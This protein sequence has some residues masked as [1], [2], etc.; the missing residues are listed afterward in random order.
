MYRNKKAA[1]LILAV[2]LIFG[3]SFSSAA[4]ELIP[5]EDIRE[6]KANYKTAE[7]VYAEFTDEKEI[8]GIEVMSN[9]TEF[10]YTDDPVY[11]VAQLVKGGDIVK[12]GDPVF[13]IKTQIDPSSIYEKER[14]LQRMEEDFESGRKSREDAIA[15]ME[16]KISETA[17]GRS[18]E[19]LEITCEKQKVQL[20]QYIYQQEKSISGLRETLEELYRKQETNYITAPA[21][22]EVSDVHYYS[23]GSRILPGQTLLRVK[24]AANPIIRMQDMSSIQSSYLRYGC[25]VTITADRLKIGTLKGKVVF[26]PDAAPLG[27]TVRTLIEV[28]PGEMKEEELIQKLTSAGGFRQG[29]NSVT[30][31]GVRARQQNALT[32]PRDAV[33]GAMNN[34]YVQILDDSNA[35]HIRKIGI[36]GMTQK[37]CWILEGVSEH[38]KVILE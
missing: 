21:D 1:A 22:G 25:E 31:H 15:D 37:S 27:K 11:F 34:Y 12:A 28:D 18:R 24:G 29:L 10:V 35:I 26:S 36:V 32:I 4:S 38:D 33:L 9:V 2:L 16:E 30:V 7:A 13:E 20:E 19:K 14:Q 17:E 3:L 6:D 23:E 5:D 8:N